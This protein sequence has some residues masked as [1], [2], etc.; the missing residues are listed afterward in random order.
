MVDFLS[1]FFSE[2]TILVFFL[3]LIR[4]SGFVSTWPVL[5]QIPTVLKIFF[6]FVF[7]LV[8]FPVMSTDLTL[9]D[10]SSLQIIWWSGKELFIGL[11]IGFLS[12]LFFF[13]IHIAGSL[14]S[15]NMGLSSAQLFNPVSGDQS[16]VIEHFHVLLIS[17]FFLMING[18]HW[19]M[20]GLVKSFEIVPLSQMFLNF[21]SFS[22]VGTI[23]HEV[24]EIGV[25]IS[26]PIMIS[27][28]FVNMSM[29][30]LGRAVPQMNVLI[31]SLPLTIMTGFIVL[32]F[33]LPFMLWQMEDLL[34]V[35]T[36]NVFQI[37]KSF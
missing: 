18:H 23:A 25:K 13:A 22:H 2:K 8:L 29:A 30:I 34:G 1:D 16:S 5:S 6:S 11:F 31:N 36:M 3:I 37:L 15:V 12:R 20:E 21:S 32:I 10:L 35:T 19:L 27:I 7:S 17:L 9:P 24:M 26:G 14:I 28:L 4:I 33:T